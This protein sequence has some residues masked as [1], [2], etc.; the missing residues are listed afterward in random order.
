MHL[1]VMGR[2]ARSSNKARVASAL[3]RRDALLVGVTWVGC[4]TAGERSPC[5]VLHT[6]LLRRVT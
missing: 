5:R 2:M 6:F 1:Q 4:T 3:M